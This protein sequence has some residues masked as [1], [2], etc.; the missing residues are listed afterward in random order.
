MG[1]VYILNFQTLKLQPTW[2]LLFKAGRSVAIKGWGGGP[3]GFTLSSL[4]FFV[5]QAMLAKFAMMVG[6]CYIIAYAHEQKFKHHERLLN[7]IGHG[8]PHLDSH[9]QPMLS[10]FRSFQKLPVYMHIMYLALYTVAAAHL[11]LAFFL[12]LYYFCALLF[13]LLYTTSTLSNTNIDYVEGL[14]KNWKKW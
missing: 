14:R 10:F 1:K 8:W 11:H 3:V 5:A 9:G 13:F 12:T 7:K 6:H 4:L 2:I